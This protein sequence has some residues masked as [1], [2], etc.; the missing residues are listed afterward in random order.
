M[1]ADYAFAFRIVGSPIGGRR[2][3]VSAPAAYA[4][5]A[6]CD[7]RCNLETESYLSAFWYGSEFR[8]YL[9]KFGGVKNYD[10]ECWSPWLWF[11]V[12]R[13]GDLGA[14]QRDTARLASHL[15]ARYQIAP[16]DL[17]IFFSGSKGYHVGCPLSW[18]PSPSVRF[19]LVARYL[20]ERIAGD[21]GIA[22]DPAIYAKTQ[23][24]RSPNSRHA[25]TGLHKRRLSL[26][27]L[28]RVTIGEIL[29]AARQPAPFNLG[30]PITPAPNEL[31]R[32]RWVEAETEAAQ[33][34]LLPSRPSKT[35]STEA[36]A[37]GEPRL[38]RATLEFIREGAAEGDRHR[39]LYSAAANLAEFECPP[40]LAYALLLEPALDSGLSPSDAKR[41]IDCGLERGA[42]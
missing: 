12:D 23:P 33:A 8:D 7:P 9:S 11:D 35:I 32:G 30:Y 13:E 22:I 38:N 39:L 40:E 24:F 2:R 41:Q 1:V 19:H 25:K 42:S 29:E 28:S 36:A 27:E 26:D 37:Q 14:A 6:A 31:L 34:A 3:L 10:G 17:L 4:A 15:V 20:A 16:K 21:V 5:Y 18:Q